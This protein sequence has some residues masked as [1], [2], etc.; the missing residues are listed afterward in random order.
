MAEPA[1]VNEVPA[2]EART[3]SNPSR[4]CIPERLWSLAQPPS[5]PVSSS[6][7]TSRVASSSTIL[8]LDG[9]TASLRAAN[10]RT[11]VELIN[12]AE[13]RG[14]AIVGIFHDEEVRQGVADRLF[15]VGE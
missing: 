11:V 13:S 1:I 7:S 8:L 3:G 5:R 9:P 10:R 14:A 2:E 12:A 6:G 4:L 15:E